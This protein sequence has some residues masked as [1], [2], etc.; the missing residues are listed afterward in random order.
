VTKQP[1]AAILAVLLL[2][3]TVGVLL[4][5]FLCGAR[6][7]DEMDR[8]LENLRRQ[9]EDPV[10]EMPRREML[11]LE[12]AATLDR[13][14]QAAGSAESRR[15]RW[16]EAVAFLD[17]FESQN[18]GHPRALEVRL[19]AAVYVWALGQSWQQHVELDPANQ[20]ARS[21]A[22]KYLDDA[23]A[24]L[25]AIRDMLTKGA[26]ELLGQNLRFR[27]GQA[28][29]DRAALDP[30]GSPEHR[31]REQDALGALEPPID[32][33]MLRGFALLLRAGLLARAGRFEQAEE[34]VNEAI[35]ARPAPP[36]ADLLAARV[37]VLA[38]RRRFDDAIRAIDSSPLG[39]SAR[40]A[41]AVHLL[42]TRR[43][44]T[45]SV[46]ERSAAEKALFGRVAA[47]RAA[48][49]PEARRA[50]LEL[51]RRLVEPDANQGPD[52]WEALAEGAIALGDVMRASRLEAQA[53]ARADELGLPEQAAK[54]RVRAGAYLFQ[55]EQYGEADA[56]LTR[57]FDNPRGGAAR[58][59]AGMLR[60]LARGRALALGRPGASRKAYIDALEAQIR[61]FPADL[62]TNEARWFLGR[63]RL[64]SGEKESAL[65]LWAAIA[66]GSPRWVEA[67]LTVARFNQDDL[68]TLRIGNDRPRID[69]ACA[70][71]RTFLTQ[72]LEQARSE[73]DKADLDLALA[74]LELTPVVGVPDEA[75]QRAEQVL[76]SASRPD[77]RDSARRLRIVA[78]A[79]LN[80]FDE[81]EKQ[82]RDE[83]ARSRPADLLE[84]GRLLDHIAADSESDLRMRRFGLIIRTLLVGAPERS[85]DLSED[86]LAEVRLRICR[87]LLFRGDDEGARRT[88]TAWNGK[89]PEEDRGF[90]RDLADTY[91]RL[92]AY[93]LAIDVERL[94]QKR[95][96]T[97]SLL[98]FESRYRV[99]LAEYRSGKTREAL[100]LIDAT[101]ILHPDLGGGTLRDKFVRLRQRIG[102]ER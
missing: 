10:T 65:T 46:T 39:A 51:A 40:D 78:L 73:I 29:A 41:L 80:R 82:A 84:I 33:S 97:G 63:L 50:V 99:A 90:L 70:A 95:L 23:I 60:A 48:G 38:G 34:A 81:A 86:Q 35:K 61:D 100:H 92:E 11:A 4:S 98:W 52:A 16:A 66:P 14:G 77:Q 20:A 58:A 55:A 12:L 36:A 7:D 21:E 67:R 15:L 6:A 30:E 69:A 49:G 53:A 2:A 62:T 42:L 91:F 37:E 27:L 56:V 85:Q 59:S 17:R 64:A 96:A 72:S 24:R 31:R 9:A 79:V 32:E 74:R 101:A 22:V 87:A 93:A 28:L 8:H 75:R 88:L 94:R 18:P 45:A 83:S 13:V 1:R 26:S 25:Q 3:G 89:I 43:A 47:L 57:V 5:G 44:S 19:Q 71:A 76:H 102:P 54:L 68:D